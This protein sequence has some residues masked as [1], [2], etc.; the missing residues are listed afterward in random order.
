[1]TQ[2]R[3]LTRK[4]VAADGTIIAEAK[5]IAIALGTDENTVSQTVNVQVSSDSS[6]SSHSASHS[7]SRAE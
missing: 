3:V 5:S 4:I 7:E 6:S 2:Y 1:M